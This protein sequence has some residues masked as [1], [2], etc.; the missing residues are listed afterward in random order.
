MKNILIR[1]AGIGDYPAIAELQCVAFGDGDFIGETILVD[2]LRHCELYDPDLEIVAEEE[3]EI[4]GHAFFSSYI[5]YSRSKPLRAVNLAPL[6]VHPASQRKGIGTL[7]IQ[8]GHR[9]A[10]RKGHVLS[11]LWGHPAFYPRFGYKPDSFAQGGL[12][13]SHASLPQKNVRISERRPSRSDIPFLAKLWKDS[14]ADTGLSIFPGNLITDWISYSRQ[15]KTSIITQNGKETGYVRYK[16]HE[17]DRP[18]MLL[19]RD[20]DSLL[21]LI[22]YLSSLQSDEKDM[23]LPLHPESDYVR[24]SLDLSYEASLTTSE[25]F[26]IKVL[27]EGNPIINRYLSATREDSDNRGLFILPP[28]FDI[29]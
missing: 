11:F 28:L 13:I 22:C 18:L 21:E 29:V 6:A 17:P 26:M 5:L 8:R 23:V 20:S 27:D 1:S 4:V 24:K 2:L 10:K 15:V 9:I 12:R 19:A 14:F 3:N 25:A 7:L 16:A